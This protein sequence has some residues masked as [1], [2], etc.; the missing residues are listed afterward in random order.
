LIPITGS[1][2]R[3]TLPR[4]RELYEICPGRHGTVLHVRPDV[5]D[6]VILR[7]HERRRLV[8]SNLQQ[9][10]VTFHVLRSKHKACHK[11]GEELTRGVA[12][13]YE[14]KYYSTV[15]GK[16]KR[17]RRGKKR[18]TRWL[19]ALHDGGEILSSC[20]AGD[21]WD[22]GDMICFLVGSTSASHA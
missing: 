4:A 20:P 19:I 6:R 13:A 15:F 21:R 17:R 16:G 12:S 3:Y 8:V 1:I 2:L 18:V 7:Q 11:E 10:H 22:Q 9:E 5:V 14:R